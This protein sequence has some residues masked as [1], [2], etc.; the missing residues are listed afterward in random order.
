[1]SALFL[2]L[3]ILLPIAHSRTKTDVLIMK[4][5][6]RITCEIKKL[7]REQL[8]IKPPYTASTIAVDWNE[9]ERIESKQLFQVVLTDGRQL[10]GSIRQEPQPDP[11]SVEQPFI[12]EGDDERQIRTHKDVSAITQL[13]GSFWE[14]LDFA[15]DFGYSFLKSNSESQSTLNARVERLSRKNF[16]K[17]NTS[18]YLT[19]RSDGANNNRHNGRLTY[20]RIRSNNWFYGALADFL[21]SD[22]QQLDLRTTV[23]GIAGHHMIATTSTT[24]GVFGGV[25]L[26]R[27]SFAN[28]ASG[29]SNTE[30]VVGTNAS[31]YQFDSTEIRSQVHVY[32]SMS[33]GGRYRVDIDTSAYLDVWGDLY[34]RLGFFDNFD[35]RPP[36]DAPRNDFGVS[37][38]VGWSF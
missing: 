7:D 8:M 4:N 28:E 23:G 3:T 34:F 5:G 2:T 36:I 1:M 9:V 11:S 6:D 16:M 31:W 14:Q 38:T 27:E 17:L 22:Q 25:V 15:V 35:S 20:L 10:Y 29:R 33:E 26:N 19:R 32:P 24:W 12:V 13:G 21:Q 37:T 18:S 30:V